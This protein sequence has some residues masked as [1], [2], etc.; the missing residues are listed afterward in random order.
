MKVFRR[1]L[2]FGVIFVAAVAGG[3]C[4]RAKDAGPGT[5]VARGAES[6]AGTVWAQP[7]QDEADDATAFLID[8]WIT[9]T[10]SGQPSVWIGD[11]ASV[12]FSVSRA[13]AFAA[14]LEATAHERSRRLQT[15]VDGQSIGPPILVLV[16]PGASVVLPIGTLAVGEHRIQLESLDGADPAA[17]GTRLSV[18]V[19]RL[20]MM[21]VGG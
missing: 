1:A 11:R 6:T 20:T 12:G 8:G 18:A 13:G 7:L 3:A 17:D 15:R 16:Q 4:S 5:Q 10:A 9:R 21:R 14:T 2:L 19:Q